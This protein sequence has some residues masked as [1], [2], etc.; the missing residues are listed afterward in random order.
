M[1]RASKI[2]KSSSLLANLLV[3]GCVGFLFVFLYRGRELNWEELHL[4]WDLFC[5]Y[6]FNPMI[7]HP[8]FCPAQVSWSDVLVLLVSFFCLAQ[9]SECNDFQ[10]L[11]FMF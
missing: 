3:V 9:V 7:S 1:G 11:C 10:F 4:I 5:L 6:I 8:F 2:L